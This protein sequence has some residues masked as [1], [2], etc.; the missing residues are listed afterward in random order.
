MPLVSSRE[1]LLEAYTLHTAVAA[2]AA[3]HW[4][5]I[6][7][8]IE[9][10][11]E[12]A[13]PIILQTTPATV[14]LMG[15]DTIAAMVRI[16]AEKTAVPVA[17]HLD[18]GNSFETVMHCLRAGYTSIMVDGSH[19][20]LEENIALTRRVVEAAHAVGVPVEGELGTI[21]GAGDTTDNDAPGFTDPE[22]AEHFVRETGIDFLAP[23]F[24]TAHGH[25][26]QEVRLDFSLLA[27][28][29]QRTQVPLVMHGA[30]GVPISSLRRALQHGISKVNV[31]TELKDAFRKALCQHLVNHPQ[32]NDPRR[33]FRPAREAVKAA[34][35]ELL[36]AVSIS[37]TTK[38]TLTPPAMDGISE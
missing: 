31:S 37:P 3:H 6:T 24:G 28:I 8:V 13:A 14:R 33:F 10:A 20:A 16:A 21:G 30:S 34:A 22:T 5:G 27:A 11:E 38:A 18:H 15:A 19:L 36:A 4:D 12:M 25:Y 9:A 29:H 7:A 23:A 35:R 26:V 1:M 17:L 2:F 32:E